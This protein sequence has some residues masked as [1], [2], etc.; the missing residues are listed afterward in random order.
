MKI[1]W[2]VKIIVNIG[3]YNQWYFSIVFSQSNSNT[4]QLFNIGDVL[5]IGHMVINRIGD[6]RRVAGKHDDI[7]Q[8][9]TNV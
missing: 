4:V 5:P 8:Y 3:R 7:N 2:V 1:N 9:E 6:L